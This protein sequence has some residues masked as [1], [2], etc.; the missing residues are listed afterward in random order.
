MDGKA[1]PSS[2]QNNPAIQAILC[3]RS[4]ERLPLERMDELDPEASPRAFI[5]L[6]HETDEASF[7][8]GNVAHHA[9]RNASFCFRFPLLLSSL[10]SLVA[11]ISSSNS[12]SVKLFF[13]VLPCVIPTWLL[14]RS[15]HG[16]LSR[17]KPGTEPPSGDQVFRL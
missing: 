12:L 5:K 6:F 9:P 13:H 1:F 2:C 11:L 10:P 3:M 16:Y 4:K 15:F 7:I 8:R 14:Q 17:L